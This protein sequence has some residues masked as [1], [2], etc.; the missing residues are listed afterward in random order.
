MTNKIMYESKLEQKDD[1]W[2]VWV[3]P[4]NDNLWIQIASCAN[5]N[6]LEETAEWWNGR[7]LSWSSPSETIDEKK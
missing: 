4:M 3:R 5:K 7:E 2:G 6:R 1:L